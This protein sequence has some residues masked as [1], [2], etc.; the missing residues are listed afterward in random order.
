ME[1]LSIQFLKIIGGSLERFHSLEKCK[2][3][4]QRCPSAERLGTT[5]GTTVLHFLWNGWGQPFYTFYGTVGD[6]RSTL[7]IGNASSALRER[8]VFH[9]V[10]SPVVCTERILHKLPCRESRYLPGPIQTS[11]ITAESGE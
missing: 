11:A 5:L 4:S 3:T 2:L 9:V 1:F 8:S 10:T 6:N 7:F